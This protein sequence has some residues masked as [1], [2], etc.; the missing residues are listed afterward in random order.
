M[1]RDDSNPV[2]NVPQ[3]VAAPMPP[4]MTALMSAPMPASTSRMDF[5][6]VYKVLKAS[7]IFPGFGITDWMLHYPYSYLCEILKNVMSQLHTGNHLQYLIGE[8]T[9]LQKFQ[10]V[11]GGAG[12]HTPESYME[13][14]AKSSRDGALYDVA[15]FLAHRYLQEASDPEVQVRFAGFGLEE[16][17][18]VNIC[19]HVRQRSLSC[20]ASECVAVLDV[21]ITTKNK[22]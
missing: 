5:D 20:E 12:R 7:F 10:S 3:P 13:F 19:K 8:C 6:S 4:P 18:W 22:L 14:E 9:G 1:P 11:L 15:S 17:E 21:S 2:R 16:D